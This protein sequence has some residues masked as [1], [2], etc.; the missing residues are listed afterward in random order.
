MHIVQPGGSGKTREGI[1]LAYAMHTHQRNSLYVVPNQQAL[2][3]FAAKAKVLCPDLDVGA[4]YQDEK[5]IGRLTFI[6]YASLLKRVLGD[7]VQAEAGTAE[8]AS[9]GEAVTQGRHL[10]IDPKHYDMVIWDE[11]HMYLTKNAKALL[12][13]FDH[14]INVG[15]TATPRYYSGKEVGGEIDPVFGPCTYDLTLAEAKKRGEICDYENILVQT[16]IQT[17]L[18]LNSPEQ[19]ESAQVA[20]AI[21]QTGRNR[22]VADL[23]KNAKMTVTRG[24]KDKEYTLAGEP[25]IVFGAGIDHVHAIAD[26]VNT[27]LMPALKSDTA[28][29]EALRA[30]GIDPD[31]V[32]KIIEPIHTGA[33]EHHD[34]MDLKE[35]NELVERY[36]QRKVLML[37]STTVLQQSFDSPKTSVVMDTIPRQTY[38]GVGQAAM[39]ALRPGKEMAFVINIEDADHPSLTLQDFEAQR[40]AEEGVA[41]EIAGNGTNA[42]KKNGARHDDAPVAPYHITSG[43]TLNNLVTQ[44]KTSFSNL[45]S[46]DDGFR[47][48]TPAGYDR[49]NHLIHAIGAGNKD[50]VATFYEML[51]PWME[52]T[53]D[54]L[55]HKVF[56]KQL[57]G[58]DAHK[59][60]DATTDA[61]M[62]TLKSI[63]E[64][65]IHS[66]SRFSVSMLSN[67]LGKLKA[68]QASLTGA[69]P[70]EALDESYSFTPNPTQALEQQELHDRL[71]ASME[72]LS[73]RDKDIFFRRELNDEKLGVLG[74]EY[75]INK[76]RVRQISMKTAREIRKSASHIPALREWAEDQNPLKR[77]LAQQEAIKKHKE[78]EETL[79]NLYPALIA[80]EKDFVEAKT[81]LHDIFVNDVAA[82]TADVSWLAYDAKVPTR[83]L[84]ALL[85][86]E[87]TNPHRF[88][89]VLVEDAKIKRLMRL[90]PIRE[91]KRKNTD[92]TT[93]TVRFDDAKIASF[94]AALDTL[95]ACYI[96]W[97]ELDM[98]ALDKD[99]IER[100]R[101]KTA[102]EKALEQRGEALGQEK[103]E[104]R[105]SIA[106][107]QD[108][109]KSLVDGYANIGSMSSYPAYMFANRDPLASKLCQRLRDKSFIPFKYSAVH[110]L[111]AGEIWRP[112]IKEESLNPALIE[113]I[114]KLIPA[115]KHEHYEELITK[116]KDQVERYQTL[117]EEEV[118]RSR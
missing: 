72:K 101:P 52:K 65:R 11:A 113:A 28:F 94:T 60:N 55:A 109:L 1:A 117:N 51:Q 18:S 78:K 59:L 48:F 104:T 73:P 114:G 103:K 50:A 71:K 115:R 31:T 69:E 105:E 41:V 106:Y 84:E 100:L 62:T 20:H 47:H 95:K 91:F 89:D 53:Q 19:E 8:E 24:D 86:T 108:S 12:S 88:G 36:H 93:E 85:D 4:V 43:E 46:N 110:N 14:A 61:F 107:Y 13:K 82:D 116:I 15:L 118:A 40:G 54:R 57:T 34:A 90:L 30:K 99:S 68:Y 80:L 17:N 58:V 5:R 16:D 83:H 66:W 29:R 75:D 26:A 87:S 32:E 42:Q 7:A 10:R 64:G 111:F 76:E 74:S 25:T 9:P 102:A 56:G 2:E 98:P 39:R 49:L 81:V 44:R 38:V 92:G 27:A 77:L 79:R 33:T 96:R 35:R 6:T 45:H 70:V 21:N 67:I 22:I 37:A 3:D 97:V 112:E 23:Y 63:Q